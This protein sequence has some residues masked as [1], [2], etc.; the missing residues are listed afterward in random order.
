MNNL[1]Y[2]LPE[3]QFSNT[4]IDELF[5]FSNL[6][7]PLRKPHTDENG[8]VNDKGNFV[9]SFDDFQFFILDDT[10]VDE[11]PESI[12]KVKSFTNAETIRFAWIDG[13]LDYHRDIR[14]T[15]LSVPLVDIDVPL[16]WV[17]EDLSTVIDTYTYKKGMPVL[18][19]TAIH[20]GTLENKNPRTMCQIDLRAEFSSVKNWFLTS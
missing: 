14:N 9:Y 17:E 18:I 19:N 15:S 6:I 2:E 20:H 4:E 8:W 1:Y 3:Y 10:Y 16:V 7:R 13:K 11:V 5:E 12:E